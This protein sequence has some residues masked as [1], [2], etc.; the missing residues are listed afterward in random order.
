VELT[1]L[2]IPGY[3]N[4]AVFGERLAIALPAIP[5]RSCFAARS[6]AS[7]AAEADMHGVPDAADRRGG[8]VRRARPDPSLSCRLYRGAAG[9]TDGAPPVAALRRVLAAAPRPE[10]DLTSPEH[11]AG[12]PARSK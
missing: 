2:T 6:P 12:F 1:L 7:E 3:P 10:P 11:M 4:A 9:Q 5:V 8:P